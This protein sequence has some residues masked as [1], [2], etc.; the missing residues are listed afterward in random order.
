M[1]TI[2]IILADDPANWTDAD[3]NVILAVK[4]EKGDPFVRKMR[5]RIVAAAQAQPEEAPINEQNSSS[6]T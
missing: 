2:E 5:D 4:K 3:R 6:D 1:R